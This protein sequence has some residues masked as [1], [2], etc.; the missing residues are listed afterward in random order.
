MHHY[1]YFILLAGLVLIV[2]TVTYAQ[3]RPRQ[4]IKK[5]AVKASPAARP[6][7]DL[8]VRL[9]GTPLEMLVTEI[10]DKEIVY[11]RFNNPSGPS[12]RVQKADFSSIKY[13]SNGEV[14]RFETVS[15]QVAPQPEPVQSVPSQPAPAAA[16]PIQ[17]TST[18]SPAPAYQ[19]PQSSEPFRWRLGVLAGVQSSAVTVDGE[20]PDVDGVGGFRGGVMVDN[21]IGRALTVRSQALF[22]TKGNANV[23][24]NYLEVPFDLLYKIP[25]ANGGILVGG[26]FYW[27]TLL[28]AKAGTTDI[29]NETSSSDAGLRLSVWGDLSSGLT[30]NVFYNYGLADINSS[31]R[32]VIKNHS[33][34][35]GVGYF[36]L[37]K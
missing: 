2:Q 10:T 11:K 20:V 34:G 12:F 5:P 24:L 36:L 13:G 32:E 23:K 26:G 28:S 14:E 29:K 9:D 27:A 3:P 17:N 33:F 8:L 21:R 35:I 31:G 22:S 6:K 18:S 1:K 4:P 37:K 15:Q 7:P 16:A 25:I 19:N 30:M